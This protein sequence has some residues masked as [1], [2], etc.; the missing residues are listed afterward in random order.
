MAEDSFK[1][2]LFAFIFVA[3]F[4]MLILT[5]TTQVADTYDKDTSEIV[6]GSLSMSKFNDSISG[7]EDS[8]KNLRADFG[9]GSIWSALAG[10]VVEGI[11]GIA[12]DMIALILSPFDIVADIMI[13]L[14]GVPAWVTSVV[15][16]VLIMGL[17]FAVW[18]LIR[19]GD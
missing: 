19:I 2:M 1:N 13:D 10:V 15:L 16:G 17:I 4:G 3:L 5:A 6:G 8:A 12:L 11:F 9:S 14:F 7:I 18:R